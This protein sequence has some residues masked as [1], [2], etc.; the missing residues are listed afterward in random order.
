M[1]RA[2]YLNHFRCSK[3]HSCPTPFR[4]ASRNLPNRHSFMALLRECSLHKDIHEGV[5]IHVEISRFGLLEGDIFLGSIL[6]DMYAKCGFLVKA[7]EV[8]DHLPFRD[9]VIWTTL[10]GGYVGYGLC[11]KAF[12]CVEKM[13]QEGI[14]PDSFTF[15]CILKVCGNS[16][17]MEKGEGIHCEI[18]RKGLLENNFFLGSMLVDMYVKFGALV[19]ARKVFD[20]VQKRDVAVWNALVGGYAEQ[21]C[22]EEAFTCLFQMHDEG[23]SP[24][25]ITFVSILKVCGGAKWLLSG[26]Q[27]HIQI[28]G[29]GLE[30][31]VF[32]RSTLIDMYAKCGLLLEAQNLFGSVLVHD[33]VVWNVLIMGYTEN[34]HGEEALEVLEQMQ[35]NGISADDVTYLCSLKACGLIGAKD[36]GTEIYGEISMRGLLEKDILVGNALLDMY[37]KCGSL[38]K[39]QELFDKLPCRDI[40]SWNSLISGYAQTGESKQV[41]VI[42][43]RMREGGNQPDAITFVLILNVCSHLGL[44]AKGTRYFEAMSKDFGIDPTLQHHTC[45]I[46]L[47][48]H[49]GHLDEAQSVLKKLPFYPDSAV[50]HSILSACWKSG[51]MELGKITFEHKFKERQ[52]TM[53][54]LP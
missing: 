1:V 3:P 30:N 35:E 16:G 17:A 44:I 23:I 22:C 49:V 28:I 18:I 54:F 50:W 10:I 46:D 19:T 33:I 15:V 24:N 52:N 25:A 51:N 31:D 43:D 38:L 47:L 40:F 27:I 13:Q 11:E 29:R 48:A 39:A 4:N 7:Q 45:M 32:I 5:R 42:F 34:D 20:K 12:E 21:G 8:F 37:A 14:A 53:I 26:Q 9:V 41:F 36:K 2:T 6:V